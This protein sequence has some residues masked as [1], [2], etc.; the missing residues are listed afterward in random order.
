MKNKGFTLIEIILYITLLSFI[1]M[2]IFSVLLNF[3]H[4][5]LYKKQISNSDYELL[6]KNFH[7]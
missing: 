1:I 4:Q 5:S 6:I 7:E 2:S 3:L